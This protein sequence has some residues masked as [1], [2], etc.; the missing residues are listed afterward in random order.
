MT[1]VPRILLQHV[2]EHETQRHGPF[3]GFV[4][5]DLKIR[6]RIDETVGERHLRLPHLKRLG[7][8][9]R[10]RARHLERAVGGG[11]S[12]IPEQLAHGAV[13]HAVHDHVR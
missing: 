13:R 5:G 11:R 8:H 2:R 6:S 9:L 12:W 1:V 3:P 7:D 10:V 4:P